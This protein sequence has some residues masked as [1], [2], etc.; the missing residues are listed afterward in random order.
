MECLSGSGRAWVPSSSMICFWFLSHINP[1][2]LCLLSLLLAIFLHP[3]FQKSVPHFVWQLHIAK[4]K[5]S[6]FHL[7]SLSVSA[8]F[9]PPVLTGTLGKEEKEY[10][11][12]QDTWHTH[13]VDFR[14]HVLKASYLALIMVCFVPK[15]LHY[16]IIIWVP[17][18]ESF[19]AINV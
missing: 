3:T 10:E 2:L 4:R 16:L 18:F 11:L 6:T 8:K 15:F 9:S 12:L 13:R 14:P 17:Y 19:I 7:C 5:T 1:Y